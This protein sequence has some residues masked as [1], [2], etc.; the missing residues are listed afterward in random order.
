MDAHTHMNTNLV[1][2][3][4]YRARLKCNKVHSTQNALVMQLQS[5]EYI[6]CNWVNRPIAT[7]GIDYNGAQTSY[8]SNQSGCNWTRT[9][10]NWAIT[11]CNSDQHCCN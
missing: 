10:C 1:N 2:I 6:N 5:R 4:I 8:N 9:N 3:N 11:S 7:G